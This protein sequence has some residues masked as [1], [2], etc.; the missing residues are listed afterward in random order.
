MF[1]R[2]LWKC[3]K[4]TTTTMT[5]T[6]T[7]MDNEQILIRKAHLGLWLGWAKNCVRMGIVKDIKIDNTDMK[8]YKDFFVATRFWSHRLGSLIVW[9]S[10]FYLLSNHYTKDRIQYIS[11]FMYTCKYKTAQDRKSLH[12]E[13][14]FFKKV[15]ICID[16]S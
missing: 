2:R 9:I 7:T 16:I 13:H 14:N 1:F 4:F 10:Y 6:T 8:P 5:T 15:M 12:T 11:M 3:E